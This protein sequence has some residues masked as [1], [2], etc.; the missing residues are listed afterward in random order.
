MS[1]RNLVGWSF[2][3]SPHWQFASRRDGFPGVVL[4]GIDTILGNVD[5]LVPPESLAHPTYGGITKND[6]SH[7]GDRRACDVSRIHVHCQ[8]GRP[9]G[10]EV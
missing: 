9:Q 3:I 8:S 4:L 6:P 5:P 7:L 1:T 10:Y 2:R